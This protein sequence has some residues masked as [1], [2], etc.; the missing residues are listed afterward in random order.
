MLLFTSSVLDPDPHF[1]KFDFE[2]GGSNP[3]PVY[4]LQ[5]RIKIH[6]DLQTC[7]EPV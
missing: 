1:K 3:D 6:Q 7:F 2:S 4:S 5:I